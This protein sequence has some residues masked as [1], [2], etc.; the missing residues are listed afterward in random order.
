[1]YFIH[2]IELVSISKI[3]LFI[4]GFVSVAFTLLNYLKL[5]GNFLW[6]FTFTKSGEQSLSE[7]DL[8]D[9]SFLRDGLSSKLEFI[10]INL[11]FKSSALMFIF[12]EFS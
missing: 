1:M 8:D 12:A 11:A 5:K 9:L 6:R 4:E 3:D 2:S 10:A 7:L